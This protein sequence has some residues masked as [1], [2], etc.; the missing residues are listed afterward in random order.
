MKL[1]QYLPTPVEKFLKPQ[2]GLLLNYIIYCTTGC[3]FNI[4]FFFQRFLNI[5][6]SGLSLFSLGISVENQRCS[7]TGRVMKNHDNFKEKT[8]YLMNTLYKIYWCYKK[9]IYL[10]SNSK[11]A[12][13]E[14]VC[15]PPL[16]SLRPSVF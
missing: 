12:A 11:P 14:H 16:S 5:L 3:S 4:V 13:A 9:D 15:K 10:W 8:Q 1:K 7:R 6:D 2:F